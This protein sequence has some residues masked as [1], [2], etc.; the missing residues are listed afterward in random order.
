MNFYS[1]NSDIKISLGSN[2]KTDYLQEDKIEDFD[3]ILADTGLNTMT[4]GRIKR[5][6]K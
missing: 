3:I 2:H 4:G 6:K 5:M 1:M